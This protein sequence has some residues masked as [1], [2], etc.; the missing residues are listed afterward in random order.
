MGTL[1]DS[2]PEMF[3]ASPKQE[4][5]PLNVRNSRIYPHEDFCNDIKYHYLDGNIYNTDR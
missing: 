5:R 1:M 4:S 2:Y 3:T